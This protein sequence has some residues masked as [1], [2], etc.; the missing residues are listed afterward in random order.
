MSGHGPGAEKIILLFQNE[1]K[2]TGI[3][4]ELQIKLVWPYV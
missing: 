3:S 1:K 4:N 2:W